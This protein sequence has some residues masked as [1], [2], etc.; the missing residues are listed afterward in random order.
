MFKKIFISFFMAYSFLTRLPACSSW[1]YHPTL[2]FYHCFWAF[3][4]IGC[5]IGIIMATSIY[6]FYEILYLPS[7]IVAILAIGLSYGLTGAL[8]EDGFADSC[9]GLWGGDTPEKRLNIMRDS[10]IG[11]Y[12]VIG[13]IITSLL[14]IT[15]LHH[16]I[17]ILDFFNL[18]MYLAYITMVARCYILLFIFILPQAS[19]SGLAASLM[20]NLS[21]LYCIFPIFFVVIFSIIIGYNS[22]ILLSITMIITCIWAVIAFKKIKGY[23]GDI[24][25]ALVVL[26]EI[27]LLVSIVTLI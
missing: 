5:M 2:Q 24:L 8:H 13:I 3:P 6:V 17:T 1:Q 12:G 26:N 9:D 23:S 11:V 10:H 15:L 19:S 7:L 25:G 21:P 4:I 16:L 18:I 22:I 27:T 14:K 20:K